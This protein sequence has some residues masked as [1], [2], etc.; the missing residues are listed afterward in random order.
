MRAESEGKKMNNVFS[1]HSRS[2]LCGEANELVFEYFFMRAVDRRDNE[3]HPICH[4]ITDILITDD[5]I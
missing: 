1:S 4:R 3:F 5:E 2:F